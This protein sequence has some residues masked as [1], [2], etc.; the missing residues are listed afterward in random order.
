[1]NR[2]QDTL[3]LYGVNPRQGITRNRVLTEHQD[4]WVDWFESIQFLNDNSGFI[5]QSDRDGWPHLY[6]HA[7]NGTLRAQLTERL[8]AV[9]GVEAIDPATRTVFFTARKEAPTR[10]DLY[11][12]RF[13]GKKLR[14]LT[15]GPYTHTVK[16][17]PDGGYFVTTY[18]SVTGTSEDGA[19]GR[20][21]AR[22]SVNSEQASPRT[23]T[24]TN[25]PSRR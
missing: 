9:T 15:F 13:D 18:S 4:S 20:A 1:M 22:S 8:W 24:S 14:R 23:S 5:V 6:L 25:S 16:V 12:V 10:T 21:T 7:M 2:G 3:L 11:A 19:G 17:S